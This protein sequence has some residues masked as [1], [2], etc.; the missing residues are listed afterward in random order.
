[1][2]VVVTV[3][4]Q[5]L[6]GLRVALARLVISLAMPGPSPV[7]LLTNSAGQRRLARVK[8]ALWTDGEPDAQDRDSRRRSRERGGL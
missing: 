2:P 3:S 5:A 6:I 7:D 8:M 4:A 1:M